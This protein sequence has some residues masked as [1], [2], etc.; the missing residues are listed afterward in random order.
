MEPHRGIFACNRRSAPSEYQAVTS[1]RAEAACPSGGVY[2]LSVL[3][4]ALS[5]SFPITKLDLPYLISTQFILRRRERDQNPLGHLERIE[6]HV[7]IS[8]EA[9]AVFVRFWLTSTP[10]LPDGALAAAQTKAASDTRVSLR[11]SS[12]A[13][14]ED[15]N[16]QTKSAMILMASG[17]QSRDRLGDEQRA[18]GEEFCAPDIYVP[19]A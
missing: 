4:T 13:W 8:N 12:G 9:L 15:A 7:D 1:D 10:A 16:C 3:Y 11:R 6:R 17:V 14:P 2:S 18:T 5:A 19:Y